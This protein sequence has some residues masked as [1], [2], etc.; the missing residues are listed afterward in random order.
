M[1]QST[2]GLRWLMNPKYESGTEHYLKA[3]D[4]PERPSNWPRDS[5]PAVLYAR[6][7]GPNSVTVRR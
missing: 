5:S 7:L 1:L 4:A 2:E 3:P 6:N